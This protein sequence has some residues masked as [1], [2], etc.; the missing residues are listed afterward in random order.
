MLVA[1]SNG[2]ILTA[3]VLVPKRLQARTEECSGR[4][5]MVDSQAEMGQRH[6]Q[7]CKNTCKNTCKGFGCV[8]DGTVFRR[9]D[10]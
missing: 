10:Q 9:L 1:K 3:N 6:L 8:V 4:R 7:G 5:E 2:V